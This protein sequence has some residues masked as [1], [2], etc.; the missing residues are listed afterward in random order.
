MSSGKPVKVD[1]SQRQ[2]FTGKEFADIPNNDWNKPENP[3][4]KGC[5]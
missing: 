2:S 1:I 4:G 3:A 5:E